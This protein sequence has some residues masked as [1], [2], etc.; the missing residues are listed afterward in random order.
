MSR[1]KSTKLYWKD[2]LRQVQVELEQ[3]VPPNRKRRWTKAY[4]QAQ[5]DL[6]DPGAVVWLPD[7][8]ADVLRQTHPV[9]ETAPAQ[10]KR[11]RLTALLLALLL[12]VPAAISYLLAYRRLT[13]IIR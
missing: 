7:E 13:S 1:Q 9:Q 8:I 5:A 10:T 11:A 3:D 12:L 2:A 6:Q 4:H